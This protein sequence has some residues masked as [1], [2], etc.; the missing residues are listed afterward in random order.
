[1]GR[2]VKPDNQIVPGM[3][4]DHNLTV[5]SILHKKIWGYL[6]LGLSVILLVF[7]L[8]RHDDIPSSAEIRGSVSPAAIPDTFAVGNVINYGSYEQDNDLTNGSESV[9][10]L[11]LAVEG[12]RALLISRYALDV[13]PFNVKWSRVTWEKSSLRKWLNGDFLSHAF[14]PAEQAR[15]LQVV[16][17]NPDNPTTGML[18]GKDTKDRIF[19]LSIDEAKIYFL[20]DEIR[21]CRGTAYAEANEPYKN[22]DYE[23]AW[24]WLRTRGASS[25]TASLVCFSG[26]VNTVGY[27]VNNTGGYLRPAFWLDLQPA[28]IMM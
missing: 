16:N 10:W 21:Q 18:G 28:N 3:N 14:S 4:R 24:W 1:M 6:I 27:G 26:Y 7:F 5:F 13:K 11:V 23:E 17:Q 15:I 22:D 12:D 19:L 20:S 25:K 2:E 8:S 9:E